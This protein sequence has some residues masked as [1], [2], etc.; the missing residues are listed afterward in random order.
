MVETKEERL[1]R[2]GLDSASDKLVK[3]KEL[4]RKLAIAYEHYRF[5]RQEKIDAFN[6]KLSKDGKMLGF[7]SLK[8]YGQVP[9]DAV[10]EALEHAQSRECFD[11]FEVAHIVKVPDPILFGRI[12]NCP[13]RFFI[14]QWDDDVKIEDILT[15]REG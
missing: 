8:D 7:T 1:K 2:L 14:S 10:L 9:P 13:D 6:V 3:A 12:N 11:S 5:V 15:E 4:Q